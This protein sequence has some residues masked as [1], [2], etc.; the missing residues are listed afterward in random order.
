M[1]HTKTSLPEPIAG[2]GLLDRRAFL[3]SSAA[4][5]S[6]GGLL[7]GSALAAPVGE[8]QPEWL[9]RPGMMTAQ[10]GQPAAVEQKR[11]VRTVPPAGRNGATVNTVAFT[12][13]DR[14]H[15]IYTPSG[16]HFN[17]CHHGIP[18]IDPDKHE[19]VI[20]GLV[21]RPIKFDLDV[22]ERYP[23]VSRSYFI[24][25]SGNSAALW[26]DQPTNVPLTTS[27]GLLSGSEW[28]GVLLS[29][30][31]D[32]AGIDPKAKWVIAEGADSGAMSRSI[33]IDRAMD[34]AMVALYQNGERLRP[35]QGYPMR[36]LSPGLEGNTSVKWLRSLRITDRP[37]MSRFETANYTDLMPDGKSL[38]FTL[39]IEVKSVI[40][41]PA[42][43]G[44]LKTKGL[45]EV[46]GLAWSGAGKIS[47]V[48]VSADGGKSWADAQLQEPVH[49]KMLTRFRI[50]WNWSGGPAVLMSRATDQ[51]GRVQPT[52]AALVAARGKGGMYHFNGIHGW[53]VG[54]D[55]SIKRAAV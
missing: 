22:L 41:R 16:L 28:T 45:L 27:H 12:P 3:G 32:E 51:T 52:R 4:F 38:Q 25:C 7:T 30:L 43:G 31:L 11:V 18:E 35:D 34:D 37:A 54:E 8:G 21:K 47:R 17:V 20:H 40:T 14:L 42:G 9:L 19:L 15:G 39:G 23:S 46:S 6:A 13:L 29:T 53:A 33:P 48:E 50:P 36:L 49:S 55:G 2:N 24:E 44:V 5:V 10:Y 1:T 26:G